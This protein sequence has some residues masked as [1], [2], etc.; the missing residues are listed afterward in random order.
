MNCSFCG[1]RK[2][3]LETKDE[4]LPFETWLAAAQAV[5]HSAQSAGQE[6]W[7]TFW[8]GE[9]LLYPRFVE[10][11]QAIH[12][13]GCRLDV[14]TNGT[15]IDRVA[16]ALNDLFDI[17]NVSFDG[18]GADD[19]AVRGEGTF[20][21]LGNNLSLLRK[22]RGKLVFLLTLSESNVGKLPDMLGNFSVLKP[23]KIV[24]QPLIYLSPSEIDA[25]RDYSRNI[26]DC[27]YPG[28]QSY[29]ADDKTAY[30]T[31]LQRQLERIDFDAYDFELCFTSHTRNKPY[32]PC[33]MANERVHIRYDGEVGFCTDF[34][35]YSGGNIK[36]DALENIF[37]NERSKAFRRA[38]NENKLA[39]CEH[40][41]WRRHKGL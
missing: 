4:S 12:H 34:F 9:P 17:I 11:A 8:G 33:A 28:L 1:Q 7:I 29:C 10:L 30:E 39:I 25:Y 38:V 20:A 3:A 36:T 41:P 14:V 40:C 37:V 6:P 32:P 27:D 26:F 13:A 2:G 21:R 16:A 23:D 19:D 35:G 5:K 31:E 18:F 24:M 22:R 15:L